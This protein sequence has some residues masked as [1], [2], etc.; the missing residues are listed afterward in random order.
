MEPLSL[1]SFLLLDSPFFILPNALCQFSHSRLI[2]SHFHPIPLRQ[3]CP[4]NHIPL[5]GILPF[6]V[7]PEDIFPLPP[8]LNQIVTQEENGTRLGLDPELSLDT[9]WSAASELVVPCPCSGLTQMWGEVSLSRQW[10]VTQGPE[11]RA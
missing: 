10:G 2:A 7:F 4:L 5:S 11:P 8:M 6:S 1:P 9:P 3:L